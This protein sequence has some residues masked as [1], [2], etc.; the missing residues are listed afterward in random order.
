MLS[1]NGPHRANRRALSAGSRVMTRR[2]DVQTDPL[3]SRTEAGRGAWP[4]EVRKLSHVTGKWRKHCCRYRGGGG[5]MQGLPEPTGLPGSRLVDAHAQI[6]LFTRARNH[7]FRRFRD[8]QTHLRFGARRLH[9]PRSEFGVDIDDFDVDKLTDQ[10]R[11]MPSKFTTRL[12]ACV[13]RGPSG[14]YA[15][16]LPPECAVLRRA[17]GGSR[18]SPAG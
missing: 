6:V 12:F 2:F 14:S 5:E 13:R 1:S 15:T 11:R 7:R 8:T 3:I 9:P 17:C 4:A 16:R 10:V 18:P